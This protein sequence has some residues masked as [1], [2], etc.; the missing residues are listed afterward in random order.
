MNSIQDA[1]QNSTNGKKIVMRAKK[2]RK[3]N[4][5]AL[6]EL[7]HKRIVKD[8]HHF[9]FFNQAKPFL[10]RIVNKGTTEQYNHAVTA[11]NAL[12]TGWKEKE[13]WNNVA[14]TLGMP[15]K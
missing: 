8:G 14:K 10:S 15:I 4:Y 13:T 11:L 7:A 9:M 12:E 3:D 5:T 2:Y 1:L 6:R